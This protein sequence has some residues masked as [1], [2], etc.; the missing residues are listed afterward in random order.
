MSDE[1]EFLAEMDAWCEKRVE[2][3]SRRAGRHVMR[4]GSLQAPRYRTILG[5]HRAYSA[6]RSFI[7]GCR[8]NATDTKEECE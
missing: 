7:H 6:M 8:L 5:E 4:A 1:L 3:L 2:A